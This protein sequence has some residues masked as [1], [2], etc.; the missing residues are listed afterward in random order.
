[1][2][3]LAERDAQGVLDFSQEGEPLAAAIAARYG[4]PIVAL[5]RSPEAEPGSLILARGAVHLAPRYPVEVVDRIG[6]GD[7]FTAGLIHGLLDGDLDLAVRLA[8]FAAAMGLATPGDI[9]YL[10]PEDLAHFRADK[11]GGLER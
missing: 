4:V 6:A 3:V 5:T 7:S 2:L 11:I 9:S 10:G 8:A 1:M